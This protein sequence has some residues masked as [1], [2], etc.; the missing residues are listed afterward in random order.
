MPNPFFVMR[1]VS[2]ASVAVVTLSLSACNLDALTNAV[3]P[4]S[5]A[6]AATAVVATVNGRPILEQDVAGLVAG[7]MDK[8][9][10]VDRVVNREIAASLARRDYGTEVH[11]AVSMVEREIA[12]NVY[13]R[14]ERQKILDS[15]TEE[16]LQHRYD[17]L[18]KD[19][20]FSG[21]K[22]VF[23]LFASAEDAQKAVELAKA[24]N[25][26]ALKAFQPV[27][28]DKKGEASFISRKEVPY[29]LGVMVAKLKAG[30]FTAPALVRNGYIVLQAKEVKTNEKP[31]L[32]SLKDSLRSA[33]A[34]E[35][36]VQNLANARNSSKVMVK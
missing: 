16:E 27:V 36:L 10:A 19:A 25:A 33:I 18:V 13:A 23:A 30:E 31:S 20:D 2:L 6:P 1:L 4:P 5:S 7:G 26:D 32:E 17:T 28:A 12:A 3:S 11:N 22:L 35:R 14:Q 24:G 8:A 29:N 15:L 9:A 34:D 21:Y